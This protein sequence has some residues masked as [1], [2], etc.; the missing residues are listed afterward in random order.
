[1]QHFNNYL[2]FLSLQKQ[3]CFFLC[4]CVIKKKKKKKPVSRLSLFH[5]YTITIQP[6]SITHHSPRH[7]APLRVILTPTPPAGPPLRFCFSEELAEALRGQA[8]FQAKG[9]VIVEPGPQPKISNL[10][11]HSPCKGASFAF[12]YITAEVG[13][14]VNFHFSYCMFLPT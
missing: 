6:V 14:W 8:G 9:L 12:H 7:S 3:E 2:V 5:Y 11:A 13:K 1:M 10:R 4:T